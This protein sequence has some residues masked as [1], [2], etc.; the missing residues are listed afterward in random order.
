MD[1]RARPLRVR[2][3]KLEDIIDQQLVLPGA[4]AGFEA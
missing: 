2:R 3:N 4:T 1:R